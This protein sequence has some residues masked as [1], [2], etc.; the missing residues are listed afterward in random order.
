VATPRD[1]IDTVFLSRRVRPHRA[2]PRD[3]LDA[4]HAAGL[5]SQYHAKVRSSPCS[6]PM[7]GSLMQRAGGF[8]IEYAAWTVGCSFNSLGVRT[9]AARLE[10]YWPFC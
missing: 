8:L 6:K 7:I 9:A 5:D 4:R 1:H 3:R 10:A 2:G